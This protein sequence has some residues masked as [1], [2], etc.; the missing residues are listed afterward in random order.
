[1]RALVCIRRLCRLD[2]EGTRSLLRTIDTPWAAP[3]RQR[4]ERLSSARPDNSGH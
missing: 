1:V 4:L 3:L 2:L